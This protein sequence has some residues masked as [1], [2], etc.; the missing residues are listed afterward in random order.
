MNYIGYYSAHEETMKT[1]IAEQARAGEGRVAEVVRGAMVDCRRDQLWQKLQQESSPLS[2]L[3]FLEMIDLVHHHTLDM[4]DPQ[5][6]PLLKV[7][8]PVWLMNGRR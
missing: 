2:H 8:G 1:E 6:Q 4:L 7:L 5:L 3:E